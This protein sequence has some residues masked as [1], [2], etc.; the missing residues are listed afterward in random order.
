MRWSAFERTTQLFKWCFRETALHNLNTDRVLLGKESEIFGSSRSRL[1]PEKPCWFEEGLWLFDSTSLC[2]W[3]Q[4]FVR[5]R[6]R[7]AKSS[8]A[9]PPT[10]P[11]YPQ[12]IPSHPC[13][14]LLHT[15]APSLTH[16]HNKTLL[17]LHKSVFLYRKIPNDTC[18]TET[19]QMLSA[20]Y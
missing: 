18:S 10:L 5:E 4:L 14:L 12:H 20:L 17:D 8:A 16:Q 7:T 3:A 1:L 2:W 11:W 6:A 15:S 9:V 13:Q 19:L